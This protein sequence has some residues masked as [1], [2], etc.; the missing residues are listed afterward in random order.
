MLKIMTHNVEI[1][2]L[3]KVRCLEPTQQMK[4]DTEFDN[5]KEEIRKK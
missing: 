1:N 5:Y 3:D 4:S 2:W